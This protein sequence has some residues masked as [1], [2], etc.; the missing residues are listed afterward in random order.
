MVF[1]SRMDAEGRETRKARP[2]PLTNSLI[3]FPR[4]PAR[5]LLPEYRGREPGL[6]GSR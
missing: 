4:H 1:T 6:C 2:S 5:L 3:P